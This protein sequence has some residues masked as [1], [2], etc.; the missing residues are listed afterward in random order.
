MLKV[1]D[2]STKYVCGREEYNYEWR[3]HRTGTHT[4]SASNGD[5]NEH[6][7]LPNMA[8][9]ANFAVSQEPFFPLGERKKML[10]QMML[11]AA[12]TTHSMNDERKKEKN[13]IYRTSPKFKPWQH[14]HEKQSFFFPSLSVAMRW[15]WCE[16]MR[17][18]TH[19]TLCLGSHK[20]LVPAP[21]INHQT[22]TLP[23]KQRREI[24][25]QQHHQ[26]PKHITMN[27]DFP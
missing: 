12:H 2:L 5:E 16:R 14:Q 15:N 26:H 22:K 1:E 21:S 6:Q 17:G 27:I 25:Q 19:L 10:R 8:L 23:T 24:Y 18:G 9:S 3:R 11:C 7:T 20:P 4:H 13:K